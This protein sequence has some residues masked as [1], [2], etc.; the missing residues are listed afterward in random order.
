MGALIEEYGYFSTGETLLVADENEA[1]VFEMCAIDDDEN[2]SVWG[3]QKVPDGEIFVAANEFRIRSVV[4]SKDHHYVDNEKNIDIYYSKFL[5]PALEKI[6]V[7]ED[8]VTEI[9]WLKAISPGEYAHPYYSLRRGWRVQN[10]VNPDLGLSP[11]VEDGYTTTYP[12]SI[13]PKNKLSL[14]Q[15]FGLYRD[16]YEGT[17]FDLTKGIAAGPYGDP[18]RFVGKYDPL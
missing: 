18:H 5:F 12:F 10:R 16:H 13:E 4:K 1:Y 15:V 3:V 14:E 7:I 6:E 9:D 8:G 17:E 11:W 2:H